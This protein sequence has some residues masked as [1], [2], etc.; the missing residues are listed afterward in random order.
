MAPTA[1]PGPSPRRTDRLGVPDRPGVATVRTTD[2]VLDVDDID[3]P[4]TF[5]IPERAYG[6]AVFAHGCRCNR[7]TP[8]DQEI[9][10]ALQRAGIGTLLFDLLS[11]AE[12][13][14]LS[15]PFDIDR[16]SRR[17]LAVARWA[18][19]EALPGSAPLGYFGV[20]VGAAAAVIAATER[21][22]LVTAVACED[23]RLD[24]AEPSLPRLTAPTLLV[25]SAGDRAIREV[26]ARATART[27]GLCDL[28]VVPAQGR[29]LAGRPAITDVARLTTSWFLRHFRPGFVVQPTAMF[30]SNG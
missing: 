22:D 5:T 17:F 15:V 11:D 9:A 1:T 4:G 27:A 24:L 25:V 3:L 19:G 7:F 18:A 2:L 8:R 23:A 6:L 28:S 14:D 16:L 30:G 20:N 12:S 29:R 10:Q 21:P 13:S 26:N